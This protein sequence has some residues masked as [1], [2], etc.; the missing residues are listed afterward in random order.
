[1]NL[2]VAVPQLLLLL[3]KSPKAAQYDLSSIMEVGCG[4]APVTKQLEDIV[5]SRFENVKILQV[6][7]MTES[8]GLLLYQKQL[9][10]P[11]SI[12]LLPGLKG[13]VVD[14]QGNALGPNE[15]GELCF[16]GKNVMKGY[17]GNEKATRETIDEDGWLH[18]GDVGYY[19]D[20]SQFFIVERLKE[21]IKYNAFQ[22]PPAEIEGILQMHPKVRE[23]GVFGIPDEKTG[24]KAVAFVV[25]QPGVDVTDQEIIEFVAEKA[26]KPKQLHGGVY[27]VDQLPKNDTGKVMR[28]IL[29]EMWQKQQS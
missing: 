14:A 26:S 16:K 12:T 5:K 17:I 23:A 1:M 19:D 25:K 29:K 18:T 27:F 15:K 6:Y 22:V 24:E 13:K 11:G 20:E 10:K 28:R 4:A 9:E 8:S 7:G 2:P 3:A 21:L